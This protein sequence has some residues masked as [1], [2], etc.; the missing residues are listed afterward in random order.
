VYL[1]TSG[2]TAD[3]LS[4]SLANGLVLVGEPMPSFESAAFS[5]LLPGG[6]CYD[7]P[8]Q[9]GLA[10][11]SCEMMLRGAGS[12]DSRAWI[13]ELENLGIERGESVGVAQASYSGATL[14]N[15]LPAALELFADLLRRP[16]LPADQLEAGRSICLQE[17]HSIDDDPSHKLMIELRRRRYPD[18]WGRTS[19]GDE[20]GIAAS[21][22]DDVR[23]FHAEHYRPN[24]TILG[25]AGNFDWP[26]LCD[27]VEELFDDWQPNVV[28][29]PI[30]ANGRPAGNHIPF[31]SGQ[32][33]VGIAFPTIP[34]KHPDYFQAWAAVGVLSSGSSSRLFTE[35]RERRG[36]CYT[37]YAS[38]HTQRDRASVL[39]YAG[40]T[41]ERAQETLDVTIGELQRLADGI[42]QGEL[43]RLKA[44]IKSS[45]IMQQE[46]TSARAGA[47][48]RD[49]YH[50]GRVRTL[51][52]M[53][54]LIDELSAA[55]IN[56]FLDKN[57][58]R[59]LLVVTLGPQ[60][61]E[62]PLGVS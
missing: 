24:G 20:G 59:D 35:V 54:R 60:P 49:W 17:L 10:A 58:P 48:A 61:L 34:Y 14:K 53:G 5:F 6:C 30:A 50:L 31:E 42:E 26:R 57:P 28:S 3:I 56:A 22:I 47:I 37:V 52:E 7:P 33:H 12:R 44:R 21:T 13:S 11:L 39:C 19:H 4:H 15:N 45:L 36:L 40:T 41:A 27:R 46:S 2:V 55:S 1:Y 43:D 8:R 18:P 9:A 38:L 23:R 29:E 51:D 25:V 62:V 32:S 16:H